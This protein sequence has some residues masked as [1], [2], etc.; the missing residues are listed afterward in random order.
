LPP[1]LSQ[2]ETVALTEPGKLSSAKGSYQFTRDYLMILLFYATGLRRQEL[3]SIQLADIDLKRMLMSVIGKGNKQRLVPLGENTTDDIRRFLPKRESHLIEK[4]TDS[5]HLFLSRAGHP[6]S[7]RSI[8][9]LIKQ[10]G[11]KEGI[12]VTPHALRHSFATHMLDNGADL[13]LIKEILGH[14]SLSTTQKYT[15]VTAETMKRVYRQ[16]HPRADRSK[17]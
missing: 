11:L 3:A 12:S 17:E 15:H 1:F 13:V 2:A 9:R 5:N 4:Q 7:V 8:N 14:A 6:L 16:A 10:F